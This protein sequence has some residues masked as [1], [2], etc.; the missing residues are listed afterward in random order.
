M[1]L[2]QPLIKSF[3]ESLYACG[4]NKQCKKIADHD[5]KNKDLYYLQDTF[6]GGYDN[7]AKEWFINTG[8]VR[9]KNMIKDHQSVNSFINVELNEQEQMN[10]L[11]GLRILQDM[12]ENG[13][14]EHY[15]KLPH[16][17]DVPP[18][19]EEQIDELCEKLSK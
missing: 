5:D 7:T 9:V 17:D 11:A 1:N 16:F 10:I 15:R 14:L 13:S 12:V 4:N 18:M 19:T 3:I 6:L 8:S 2:T